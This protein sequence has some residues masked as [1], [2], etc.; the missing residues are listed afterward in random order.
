MCIGPL[1]LVLFHYPKGVHT[2]YD[3]D[4]I[5][6]LLWQECVRSIN[7][8]ISIAACTWRNFQP[9]AW[10]TYFIRHPAATL[11]QLLHLHNDGG[12]YEWRLWDLNIPRNFC[13][14]RW[15][16]IILCFPVFQLLSHEWYC[17]LLDGNRY[18]WLTKLQALLSNP[19]RFVCLGDDVGQL[20]WLTLAW[21][22]SLCVYLW[23]VTAWKP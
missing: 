17:N 2:T 15:G 3:D 20:P 8:D 19:T 10:L 6:R 12:G 9:S 13:F 21:Y 7:S 14:M 1:W 16:L 23:F 11:S 22:L 5:L 4:I 18:G